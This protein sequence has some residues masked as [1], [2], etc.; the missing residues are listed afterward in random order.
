ME[1]K[2]L[3]SVPITNGDRTGRVV[4]KKLEDS[5]SFK[6]RKRRLLQLNIPSSDERNG[7]RNPPVKTVNYC[8][9]YQERFGGV[10]YVVDCWDL[11]DNSLAKYVF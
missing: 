7:F 8:V 1:P 2:C 4:V 9:S 3:K 10:S 5:A 11:N 6:I